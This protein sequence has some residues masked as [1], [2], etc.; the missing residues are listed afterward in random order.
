M[1]KLMSHLL[2]N[3][4]MRKITL[5]KRFGALGKDLDVKVMV[6][7]Q[8]I[9]ELKVGEEEKSIEVYNGSQVVVCQIE[10]E[11]KNVYRSNSFFLTGSKSAV[12]FLDINGMRINIKER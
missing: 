11:D 8:I 7:G 2:Y 9:S 10:D 5:K 6:N 12:A 4:S 3:N 1:L